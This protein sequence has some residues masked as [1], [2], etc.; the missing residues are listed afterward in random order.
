MLVEKHNSSSRAVMPAGSTAFTRT[1]TWATDLMPGVSVDL[2]LYYPGVAGLLYREVPRRCATAFS[3]RALDA[4]H[5]LMRTYNR[6]LAAISRA[7][8]R[9]RHVWRMNDSQRR[10]RRFRLRTNGANSNRFSRR[11]CRAGWKEGRLAWFTEKH[12][13]RRA[14]KPRTRRR[15]QAG[16][17]G[18]A[19]S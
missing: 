18:P 8:A 12:A 6:R 17:A 14:R 4:R 3:S 5:H 2:G 16:V 19:L 7:H 11:C 15:R 9:A 13:P 10:A 1:S